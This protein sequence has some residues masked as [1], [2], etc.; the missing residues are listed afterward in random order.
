[1][2]NAL[3]RGHRIEIRGFGHFTVIRR[4]P[5]LG[6]CLSGSH[7]E[8]AAGSVFRTRR[9]A[10]G[11]ALVRQPARLGRNPRNGVAVDIPEKRV[12][13]FKVVKALREEVDLAAGD[14]AQ[15][16]PK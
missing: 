12:P 9:G 5:Q 2:N 16:Q 8:Y 15:S 4:A 1:M 13:H 7:T 11:S 6:P 3:V 10:S 14:G